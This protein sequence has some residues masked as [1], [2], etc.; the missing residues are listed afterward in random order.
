MLEV[1]KFEGLKKGKNLLVLGS[2][3]GD[4][5]CGPK[6]IYDIIEKIKSKEV[7]I[8]NG[9]ITFIP[10]CNPKAYENSKRFIDINLN[11]VFKEIK[12]PK[13]Y[14]EII[15]QEIIKHIDACDYLLDIHSMPTD[16]PRFTFLD[17]DT[18]EIKDFTLIQNFEHIMVGWNEIFGD[19]DNSSCGY[20][21]RQNKVCVTIEC[22][23]HNNP[24]CIDI[25]KTAIMNSISFLKIAN[26]QLS[27][28]TEMQKYIKMEKVYYKTK[29]GKLTKPWKH[30]DSIK[31]G[32]LIA[33]FDDS[34]EIVAEKDYLIILPHHDG[35]K[36][37]SEWFYLGN[38]F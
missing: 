24:S 36:L 30:L 26:N 13:L 8:E 1:I 20:G 12:E 17:K 29:D 2:V 25:A 5:I 27:L 23:N 38:F 22:G 31:S 16:G 4:E 14:E 7:L 6:S 37:G 33:K 19:E 9:S 10:V 21:I 35:I 3:H 18:K 15:S 11:R 34:E 32:E 28:N